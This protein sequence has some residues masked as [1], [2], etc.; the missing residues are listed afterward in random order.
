MQGI[1]PRPYVQ[2]SAAGLALETTEEQL[3]DGAGLAPFRAL[4]D[5]LGLG[6]HLNGVLGW[7]RGRYRPALHIEQ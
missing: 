5:R 2:G 7:V 3:T 6:A 4:W 1:P